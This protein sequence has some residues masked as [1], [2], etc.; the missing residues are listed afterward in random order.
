MREAVESGQTSF[1]SL[2]GNSGSISVLIKDGIA[3]D[4]SNWQNI[5]DGNFS[6]LT[7]TV[8]DESYMVK[9]LYAHMKT[10]LMKIK[11]LFS[12]VPYLTIQWTT[13]FSTS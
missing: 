7:L 9:C 12:F 8:K 6:K 4:E 11:V 2:C 13:T 1:N 5:I 3:L 10:L